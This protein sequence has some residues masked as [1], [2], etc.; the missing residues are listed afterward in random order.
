[1]QVTVQIILMR[2]TQCVGSSLVVLDCHIGYIKAAAG[3][4]KAATETMVETVVSMIKQPATTA[5]QDNVRD[6][7]MP[8]RTMVSTGKLRDSTSMVA[9][10]ATIKWWRA[11]LRTM[12]LFVEDNN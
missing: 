1:M 9:V 3:R 2:C 7:R 8:L 12:K 11:K 4:S 5:L 10:E 6:K